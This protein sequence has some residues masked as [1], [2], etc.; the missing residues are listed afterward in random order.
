MPDEKPA[1]SPAYLAWLIAYLTKRRK[2][3]Q[4]QQQ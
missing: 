1:P 3:R 4:E 2:Q